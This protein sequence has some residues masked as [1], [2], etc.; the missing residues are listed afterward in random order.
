MYQVLSIFIGYFQ[1]ENYKRYNYFKRLFFY[2]FYY[3]ALPFAFIYLSL[4]ICMLLS[5]MII[6]PIV[7]F[8]LS[9]FSLFFIIHFLKFNF[10]VYLLEK[11]ES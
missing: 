10:F 8:C 11:K 7:T 2:P 1:L 3:V 5:T 6:Y 9:L 4:C